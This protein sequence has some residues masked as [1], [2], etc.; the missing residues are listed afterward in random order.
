MVGFA[1]KK[2][3]SKKSGKPY[4]AVLVY[5]L[6]P[7]PNVVGYFAEEIWVPRELYDA[8]AGGVPFDKL[9][10]KDCSASYDRRGFIQNFEIR[11]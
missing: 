1:E 11:Q 10:N 3:T 5:V 6:S 2:G 9:L 8:A 4:D 7:R